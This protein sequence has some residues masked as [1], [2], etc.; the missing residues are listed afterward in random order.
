MGTG[1]TPSPSPAPAP[2]PAPSPTPPPS[3]TPSPSAGCCSWDGKYCGDTTEYCAGNEKQCVECDGQW[4]TDCL[5]PF[6]TTAGPSPT[7]PPT[8]VPSD[9]PG[10]SRSA[11]I[12]LC[13]ADIFAE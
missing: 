6:T 9:C 10:G 12:D 11:C 8:P 7:P 5:P 1:P 2:S 3:P 4:C 13:P